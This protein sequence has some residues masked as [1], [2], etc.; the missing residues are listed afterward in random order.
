MFIKVFIISMLIFL[1]FDFT[2]LGFIAKDLY[3]NELGH[4]LKEKVNFIAAFIFYVIF[5][6]G[7]SVFVIIPAIKNNSLKDVLI[8]GA[9]FG[10]V[11]YATYDLTNYA[12]LEGFKLKI[13]IIDLLWGTFLGTITATLTYFIYKGLL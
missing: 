1:I 11:T 5:I 6:I 7:I 13:V 9:L 12:T 8:F 4:L 3:K 2:W 10:L